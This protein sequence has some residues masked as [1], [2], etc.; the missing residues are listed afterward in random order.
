VPWPE[1]AR[2]YPERVLK[3]PALQEWLAAA[4]LETEVIEHDEKG[5][6]AQV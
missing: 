2:S 4:E 3:S 6:Q 5:H 1:A